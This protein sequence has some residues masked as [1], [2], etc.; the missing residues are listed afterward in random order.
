MLRIKWDG[1]D[2]VSLDGISIDINIKNGDFPNV[3]AERAPVGL[4]GPMRP[5]EV[6]SSVQPSSVVQAHRIGP[7]RGAGP[8]VRRFPNAAAPRAPVGLVGP[9]R[10][11]QVFQACNR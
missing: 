8:R 7:K 2:S 6:L 11:A 5:A 3:A 10:P 4:V 1:G 9:M